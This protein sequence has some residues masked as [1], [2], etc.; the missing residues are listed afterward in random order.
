MKK[1]VLSLMSL[2]LILALAAC[3][4]RPADT[5]TPV[6]APAETPVGVAAASPTLAEPAPTAA[7][8][9]AETAAQETPAPSETETAPETPVPAETTGAISEEAPLP[10]ET[11]AP[12]IPETP[13]PAETAAQETPAPAIPEWE[14]TVSANGGET[15]FSSADAA[16]LDIITIEATLT[17]KNGE[18]HTDTYTGVRLADILAAVSGL[19]ISGV[20]IV[21][22]DGFSVDF[23]KNLALAGDTVLAWEINGELIGTNPPLRIVPKQG[24]GN[25]FVK[26]VTEI[27]VK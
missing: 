18:S 23:D 13:V 12:E 10:A 8:S 19:D 20:T 27:I 24:V 7:P 26:M 21:A 3:S 4:P 9:P 22:S 11:A 17:N 5:E 6:P 16:A 1:K 14:I 25:Q 2:I 15:R